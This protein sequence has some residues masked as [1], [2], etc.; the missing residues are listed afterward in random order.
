[1][2]EISKQKIILFCVLS[3]ICFFISTKKRKCKSP[4]L[5]SLLLSRLAS[6][7]HGIYFVYFYLGSVLFGYHLIHFCIGFINLFTWIYLINKYGIGCPMTYIE[8]LLCTP[9]D[10]NSMQYQ[11]ILRTILHDVLGLSSEKRMYVIIFLGFCVLSY[12]L[13]NIFKKI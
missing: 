10:E 1:M 11:D 8:N 4:T 5:R 7:I 12:D 6:L 13:Y 3:I 9:E 2:N